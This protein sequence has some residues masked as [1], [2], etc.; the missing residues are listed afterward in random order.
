MSRP[1]STGAALLIVLA[2]SHLVAQQQGTSAGGAV[3]P[4]PTGMSLGKA[5]SS[6]VSTL[7]T[8]HGN[9][10]DSTNGKLPNATVRLRDARF[11]RIVDTQYTDHSGMFTFSTLDPGSY[12][13]EIVANDQSIL[14]ASQ[15]LNV[16][17]G[18]AVS[19]IVKLPFRI[20]PF[21]SVMGTATTQAAAGVALEA[22][23]TGITALVPT[24]PISPNQ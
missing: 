8:I 6:K 2:T 20:P 21:A 4:P 24:A 1:I 9:A 16:H 3:V 7:T 22:A 11:G 10:L 12:I 17:G 14:A 23:A 5:F 18:E 13:V 15:L 19:A